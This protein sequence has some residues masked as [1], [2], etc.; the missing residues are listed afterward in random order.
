MDKT[1]AIRIKVV[2]YHVRRMK[3]HFSLWTNSREQWRPAIGVAPVTVMIEWIVL[4]AFLT[5]RLSDLHIMGTGE[6]GICFG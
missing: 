2:F 5:W 1:F 3:R 4:F 6:A